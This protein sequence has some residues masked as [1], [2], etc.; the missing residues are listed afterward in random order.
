MQK[1]Q[2]AAI[3]AL[4]IALATLFANHLGAVS[5]GGVEGYTLW[6]S[7]QPSLLQSGRGLSL[8]CVQQPDSSDEAVYWKIEGDSL[9]DIVMTNRRKANLNDCGYINFAKIDQC[10]PQISTYYNGR[11]NGR[12]LRLC[13]GKG[14]RNVP[15]SRLG[16]NAETVLYDRVLNAA[17]RLKV[18]TYLALKHNVTLLHDNRASD[19]RLLWDR[20][21]LE[22][23]S[24][25]IAGIARDD[26]SALAKE[27][28]QTSA[29]TF[30]ALRPLEN[31]D[32]VLVGDNAGKLQFDDDT[33]T[34]YLDRKWTATVTC[35][36]I[37]V[38]VRLDNS[39]LAELLDQTAIESFRLDVDGILYTADKAGNFRNVTLKKGA[40]TIGVTADG[41]KLK[42]DK[43]GGIFA[44]MEVYPNPTTDGNVRIRTLMPEEMGLTV[45]LYDASGR[46]ISQRNDLADRF[47]DV[48][49]NL[50]S[51]GI[52]MIQLCTLKETTNLSIIR[53]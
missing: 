13:F 33:I 34:V 7:P 23:F 30:Q 43:A 9:R 12:N 24:H 6:G 25:N 16:Q 3:L 42:R 50:P 47:H 20:T 35:D 15:V 52:Y 46:F 28:L 45:R 44:N 5:P 17:E 39:Q 8:F 4:T 18:E 19:Y 21:Q 27:T 14:G 1:T 26:S 11:L 51:P 31:F 2:N 48:T 41:S 32:F 10:K 49:V 40:N 38:D 29:L 53:K 37:S 22:V 36:S